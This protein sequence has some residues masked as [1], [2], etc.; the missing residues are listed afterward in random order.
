L[1]YAASSLEKTRVLVDAGADVNARSDDGRTAL[2]IA[3]GIPANIATVKL[4]L[5][6]GAAV[7]PSSRSFADSTPLRSAIEAPDYDIAALLVERGAD[8]KAAGFLGL[9]AAASVCPT[10]LD[11][12]AG[13][14]EPKAYSQALI[15][16]AA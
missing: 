15:I 2:F 11:L 14:F 6:R 3:S 10:C 12:I 8:I 1:V 5:D 13:A 4:L 16:S 9:A 7:N